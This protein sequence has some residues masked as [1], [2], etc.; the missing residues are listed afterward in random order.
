MNHR[1][2]ARWIEL[3]SVFRVLCNYRIPIKLKGNFYEVVIRPILLYVI[4]C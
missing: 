2:R 1:V 4:E 3:R